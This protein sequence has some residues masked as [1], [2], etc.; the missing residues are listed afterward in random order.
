MIEPSTMPSSGDEMGTA[1][2]C[3]SRDF[4]SGSSSSTNTLK[5]RS[6]VGIRGIHA[7]RAS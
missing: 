5:E 7:H 3:S 4:R 2:G 1:A 6:W